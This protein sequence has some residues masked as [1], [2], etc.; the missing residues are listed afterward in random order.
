[1]VKHGNRLAKSG[2]LQFFSLGCCRMSN[3]KVACNILSS[4]FQGIYMLGFAVLF[5]KCPCF[6][7][8][9]PFTVLFLD[10]CSDYMAF[11]RFSGTC[12]SH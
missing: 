3:L 11:G 10:Q 2:Y 7:D 9:C 12:G 8:T 6:C 4:V 1:M 5:I